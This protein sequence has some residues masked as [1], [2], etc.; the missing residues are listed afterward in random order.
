MSACAETITNIE[1]SKADK[2][3]CVIKIL[4][5]G[6]KALIIS[7]KDAEKSS[8]ALGVNIGS[9]TDQPDEMGLAH[10][11]EHLLFM[12]TEKYPSEEEYGDYLS[13][14]GGNSN[15]FTDLDKT[16]FYFDV[17]NEHFEG[18]LDRFAQFFISPKF[19]EGSVE[20]ELNAIDSEFSKEKTD[21]EWRIC[22]IFRSELVKDSPFTNFATGN[23]QTLN[24]PNIRDRL[25]R[26]YNKYYSSEV[27]YLIAYS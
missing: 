10:F 21:D 5:N 8:A 17:D 19:N 24:H 7:D 3:D 6:L 9:L 1:K 12:G 11:C 18:A 2:F 22:Q 25:L 20:R 23:K 14:N 27:M 4:A 13:K 26:M 16:I 15:A